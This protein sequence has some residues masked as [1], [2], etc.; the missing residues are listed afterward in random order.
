MR[1]I[2]TSVLITM[3]SPENSSERAEKWFDVNREP[4]LISD[5][6]IA[7]FASALAKKLRIGV[8]TKD[9][10]DHAEQWFGRFIEDGATVLPVSRANFRRAA[11][12]SRDAGQPLQSPDALHLSVAEERGAILMTLDVVQAESGKGAGIATELL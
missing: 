12:L 11:Q 10:R 3:V 9:E 4:L 6:S 2:D 7:E 1:Y 8:I 5:W